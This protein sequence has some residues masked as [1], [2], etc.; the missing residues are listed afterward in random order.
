MATKIQTE[1]TA[2]K[3]ELELV[4]AQAPVQ[5]D[6]L[7]FRKIQNLHLAAFIFMVTQF[8]PNMSQLRTCHNFT[9]TCHNLTRTCHNLTRTCHNLTRTCHNLTRTCHNLT[10]NCHNLT[11]NCHNLT[12]TCHNLT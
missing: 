6:D 7:T 1:D 4:V 8:D 5:D 2:D 12:R 10:R 3:G 11:R 9:R